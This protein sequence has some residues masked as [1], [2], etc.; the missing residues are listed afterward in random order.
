MKILKT[1]RLVLRTWQEKDLEPFAAMNQ[2]PKVMECFPN[3]LTLPETH[4]MIERFTKHIAQHG[5]GL[6]A[7]E[8]TESK[9]FM[10]FVGLN[11]PTITAHFTPCVEVGWRLA[12]R[13]WDKGFATEAAKAVLQLGF[14]EYQLKEIVAFTAEQNKRSR[15]VM[16]KLGMQHDEIDNF[17]HPNIP[18]DHPLSLHVLYR[19]T[20]NN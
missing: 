8:L 15:R 10:G 16:E 20:N 6:F 2:D 18:K 14:N 1:E 7:C 5:F 9:E 19:I 4:A 12:A 3:C 13:F 17:Y 11:I